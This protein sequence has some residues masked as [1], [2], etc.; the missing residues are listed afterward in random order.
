MIE[1]NFAKIVRI[2]GTAL[3]RAKSIDMHR[4]DFTL[5]LVLPQAR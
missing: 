1:E 5:I 4:C 2:P 3:L